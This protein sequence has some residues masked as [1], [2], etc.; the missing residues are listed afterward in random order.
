MKN[1]LVLTLLLTGWTARGQYYFKD[2][3]SLEAAKSKHALYRSQEVKSVSFQSFDADNQPIEGFR[4]EQ[5]LSRNYLELTSSTT[6]PLG[7]STFSR[8]IY[9][10]SSELVSNTDTSD[11][12]STTTT[13]AYEKGRPVRIE[14][15]STSAGGFL[16]TELHVW[17]Y[18]DKGQ[19][20]SMLKIRNGKDT[21]VVTFVLDENGKV[22]EEKSRN[23]GKDLPTY[24]Y[25]YEA[26]GRLSDI[27]RYNN[28]ARR[29]LP[30]Y[31][32]EYNEKGYLATMMVIA[33]GTG[34]YQKWYYSYDED[35]LK[36]FDACYS[37]EKTLIAKIE[38]KYIYY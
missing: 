27:V 20:L 33:E 37:K 5:Q 16:L 32:F 11:G 4:S 34:D 7:G 38:A 9:N 19:P 24:Y 28:A 21:T 13:Y 25:Y 15:I 2:I 1:L 18:N 12:A 3:L 26:G 6:S 22:V 36:V 29:L 14:S 30:D 23:K 31:I 8:S 35:G 10:A 17:S